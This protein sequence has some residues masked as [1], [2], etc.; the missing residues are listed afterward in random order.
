M[1]QASAIHYWELAARKVNP[2]TEPD[3]FH[4]LQ[5]GYMQALRDSWATGKLSASDACDHDKQR[6]IPA[7]MQSMQLPGN[8]SKAWQAMAR[9]VGGIQLSLIEEAPARVE[10]SR[11]SD[12]VIA[13]H[14][15]K[16]SKYDRHDL[17]DVILLHARGVDTVSQLDRAIS[18]LQVIVRRARELGFYP[19]DP[20]AIAAQEA[21]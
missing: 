10:L 7:R 19:T 20:A 8:G 4:D 16:P 21:A 15:G 6:V 9:K 18:H 14:G 12:Q 2:E 11:M 17:A 13:K 5:R 1:S 3:R